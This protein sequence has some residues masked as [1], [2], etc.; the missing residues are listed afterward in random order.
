MRKILDPTINFYLFIISCILKRGAKEVS[1]GM[2]RGGW[3][4]KSRDFGHSMETWMDRMRGPRR[5][6]TWRL[7]GASPVEAVYEARTGY[8]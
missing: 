4:C 2:A 3:S 5:S 7:R 1:A 8:R 6:F